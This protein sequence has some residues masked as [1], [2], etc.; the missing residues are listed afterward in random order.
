MTD[1]IH[2]AAASF[3]Q[4]EL[5]LQVFERRLFELLKNDKALGDTLPEKLKHCWA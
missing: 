3:A 4:L 2:D 5:W 1:R